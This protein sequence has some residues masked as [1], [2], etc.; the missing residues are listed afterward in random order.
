MGPLRSSETS[1]GANWAIHSFNVSAVRSPCPNTPSSDTTA[2][3]IGNSDST[4]KNVS[5][6]ARSV[7]LSLENSETARF[8]A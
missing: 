2:S 4:E 1:S 3:S 6:A 8:A 7:T 5:P